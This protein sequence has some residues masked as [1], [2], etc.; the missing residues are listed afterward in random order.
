ML[1]IS[2]LAINYVHAKV[3]ARAR[4]YAAALRIEACCKQMVEREKQR[5]LFRCSRV[6]CHYKVTDLIGKRV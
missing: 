3:D 6:I 2:S 1:L 5:H 4:A